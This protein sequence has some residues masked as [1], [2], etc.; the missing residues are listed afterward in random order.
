MS[1][2]IQA[3]KSPR[4]AYIVKES[5]VNYTSEQL[6]DF[7]FFFFFTVMIYSHFRNIIDDRCEF[8][9]HRVIHPVTLVW[10]GKSHFKQQE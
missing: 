2:R 10:K 8:V 7:F 9:S 3:T 5:A 4:V 1:V 6:S